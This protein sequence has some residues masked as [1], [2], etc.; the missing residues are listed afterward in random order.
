M[1]PI[2]NIRKIALYSTFLSVSFGTSSVMAAT[3]TAPVNQMKTPVHKSQAKAA[4]RTT[5]QKNS[6]SVRQVKSVTGGEEGLIVTGTH[7]TN[8]H[9]RQSTSPI[10]VLSSATLR[11]S[12]QMNLADALA[13]TYPSINMSTMGNDAGALTSF[14]RM[15]GLNPNQ[16]SSPSITVLLR[17][18]TLPRW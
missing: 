2:M 1:E 18:L 5:V 4:V 16:I 6:L 9:A 11:R 17:V 14:I 7:A 15:R 12:G 3:I 8:R 13:K 10:T